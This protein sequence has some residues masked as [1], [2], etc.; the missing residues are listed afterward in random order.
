[1]LT[2][3]QEKRLRLATSEAEILVDFLRGLLS[4]HEGGHLTEQQRRKWMQDARRQGKAVN[5]LLGE[6]VVWSSS[7]STEG[8][9]G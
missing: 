4:A 8:A 1:M 2:E 7:D 5:A 3:V 6:V 9:A